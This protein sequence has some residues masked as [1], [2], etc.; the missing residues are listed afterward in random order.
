MKTVSAFL[1]Q[2][3]QSMTTN[4]KLFF[5]R[6]FAGCANKEKPLYLLLFDAIAAQKKYDE[7]IILKKLKPA[8][9]AKNIAYQKHYL[10]Q[11]VCAAIAEYDNRENTSHTIYKQILLIRVY[12]KKGLFDEAFAV[13]EK[14]VIAARKNEAFAQLNLLKAE[15]EKIILLSN[16]HTSYDNLHHVFQ[17]NIITYSE[18]SEM[19]TLRDAYTEVI[20][21]KRKAHFDLNTK[22]KKRAEELLTL[23]NK[24][25]TR[26]ANRSF[27]FNH[28]YTMSKATLLYLLHRH[29]ESLKLLKTIW[30]EWKKN[31]HFILSD[32]EFYIEMLYMINYTG[33]FIGEYEFVLS[34][35]NDSL[36][37]EIQDRVHKANFETNKFLAF[38]KIYNK[39]V[40]Y[41]EVEK[42]CNSMKHKYPQWEPFLNTDLNRTTNISMGISFFVLDKYTE[43]LY[44]IKRS[45]IDYKDGTREEQMAISNVFLLVI[46][47]CM[48]HPKLFDAQYRATYQYFYKK[49]K[50]QPFETALIQCLHRTFY[51]QDIK[52][53][54]IEYKKALSIF[55]NNKENF[56]QQQMLAV[57][58]YY[59]WLKSRFLRIN[60]RDYVTQEVKG[61]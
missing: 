17:G 16:T 19:I 1:W 42:L 25:H 11:Q 37:N 26:P 32:G 53:K 8:L 43:A 48:N 39:T 12:R 60:Y 33:I 22:L 59:R 41:D 15:F 54:A 28:Y 36:N 47:Y 61:K 40:Q 31:K 14:A 7:E 30:A 35:F 46:T 44:Y 20:F 50:T 2:L 13:W 49:E 29:K 24:V 38:N 56:I 45:L 57:F 18:Y 10:Q 34:V 58:N 21:L 55:D 5:K 51:M 23:I 9:N 27:W 52:A 4:E 6:N 3:V